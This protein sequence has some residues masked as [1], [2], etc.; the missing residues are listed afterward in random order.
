MVRTLWNAFHN[1]T[2]IQRVPYLSSPSQ[3][4]FCSSTFID[5][6]VLNFHQKIKGKL[7]GLES[8]TK[9][10]LAVKPPC[11]PIWCNH[12]GL[13]CCNSLMHL[14]LAT[15]GFLCYVMN[16]KGGDSIGHNWRSVIILQCQK[17]HHSSDLVDDDHHHDDLT[18]VGVVR[19]RLG[20]AHF[21][22]S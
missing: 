18:L 5:I 21:F 9:L 1:S 13:K 20:S 2:T 8:P 17:W 4:T 16:A 14:T 3:G 10:V 12:D 6:D 15:V 19:T 11:F 7:I 22:A